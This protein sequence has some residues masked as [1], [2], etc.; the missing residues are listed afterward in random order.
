MLEGTTGLGTGSSLFSS[1]TQQCTCDHYDILFES[2]RVL[3]VGFGG[4]GVQHFDPGELDV[5]RLPDSSPHVWV[6]G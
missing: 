1:L 2:I 6:M 4:A 3:S 5:A